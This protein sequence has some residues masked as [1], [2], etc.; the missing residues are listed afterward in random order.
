MA[1]FLLYIENF[2]RNLGVQKPQSNLR[3]RWGGL[4]NRQLGYHK[5]I[6]SPF[7]KHICHQP[8]VESNLH[9]VDTTTIK[10]TLVRDVHTIARPLFEAFD[11]FSVTE[12]RVKELIK[13][14]FDAGKET[15]I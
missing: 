4:E 2:S 7:Q 9:I 5:G 11:F 12:E 3:I 1:E 14:L 10:T 15:N 13:G 6:V 8:S